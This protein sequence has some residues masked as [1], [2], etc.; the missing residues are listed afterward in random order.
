MPNFRKSKTTLMDTDEAYEWVYTG[1]AVN[2]QHLQNIFKEEGISSRER[3]DFD[4]GL[5]AGFGGGVPGQD[6]LFVIKSRHEE[7]LKIVRET[8]PNQQDR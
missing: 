1:A 3:N 8:F 2:V 5:R 4:S 7:A 6:Q